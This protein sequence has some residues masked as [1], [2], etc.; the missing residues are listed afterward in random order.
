MVKRVF[1]LHKMLQ[2]SSKMSEVEAVQERRKEYEEALTEAFSDFTPTGGSQTCAARRAA[3]VGL[4][5]EDRRST[6]Q[7]CW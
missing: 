6:D 1:N 2:K 3:P 4:H 7:L 5:T